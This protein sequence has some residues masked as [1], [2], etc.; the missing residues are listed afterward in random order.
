MAIPK[1]ITRSEL[2]VFMANVIAMSKGYDLDQLN[3]DNVLWNRHINLATMIYETLELR[4]TKDQRSWPCAR[5]GNIYHQK[6]LADRCLT[7]H[8][9]ETR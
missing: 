8:A 1:G 4:V 9:T 5:C 6:G 2:I 7:N 3:D